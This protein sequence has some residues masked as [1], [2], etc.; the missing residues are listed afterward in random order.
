MKILVIGQ[1]TL[2]WGRLE[3]GNIG[4]YY[5]IEPFFKELHRVFPSAE[6]RTS[7]QMSDEFC[8]REKVIRLPIDIY[9]S[10]EDENYL[11]KSFEEYG[12]ASFYNKTSK[13]ISAT[14]FIKEVLNADLVIDMSAA[15]F[16]EFSENQA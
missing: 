8:N 11:S 15:P 7:L 12:I 14:P 9:Y 6:I 2:H 4:N 5:V 13:L 16:L 10:W 3:F 1:T